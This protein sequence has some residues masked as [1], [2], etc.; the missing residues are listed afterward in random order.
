M[1]VA[2]LMTEADREVTPSQISGMVLQELKHL[3]G[4]L[5]RF[6]DEEVSGQGVLLG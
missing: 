2:P 6:V 4:S 1:H 3:I 5:V